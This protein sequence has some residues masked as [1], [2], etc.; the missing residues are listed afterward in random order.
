MNSIAGNDAED[1]T[2]EGDSPEK[3]KSK[4]DKRKVNNNYNLRIERHIY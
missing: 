2:I 3:D 4:T 1:T